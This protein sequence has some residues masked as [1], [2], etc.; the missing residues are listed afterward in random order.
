MR[1]FRPRIR[2][3]LEWSRFSGG[4]D[5]RWVARDPLTLEY[6]YFSGEEK[7]AAAALD[8]GRT[9]SEILHQPGRSFP[10]RT[11][12]WILGF[13][14][15]MDGSGLL[16]HGDAGRAGR[17]WRQRNARQKQGWM[18]TI[19]SPLSLRVPLFDPSG[20]MAGSGL[21]GR[22][23]FSRP[24]AL[25]WLVVAAVTGWL[26]LSRA[27]ASPLLFWQSFEAFR[28]ENLVWLVLVWIA[29]KSLHEFGHLLACRR[30][31][32]SCREVGLM[33]LVFVPCFYCDTSD[34]WKLG[35]RWRRAAIAAAGIYVELVLATLGGIGWLVFQPGLLQGISAHLLLLCTVGTLL[36]NGN[37]LMRYDGY[38]VFADLWGVPNLAEQSR[39]VLQAWRRYW[40]GGEKIDASRWD[41]RPLWLG[42][43][44]LAAL[45]Y[46]YFVVIMILVVVWQVFE[47]LGFSLAAILLGGLTA[48]GILWTWLRGLQGLLLEMTGGGEVKWIRGI[49]LVALLTAA[50]W[51]VAAVRFPETARSRAVCGWTH[52][53][54]VFANR[55]G[56]LVRI[57]SDGEWIEK[58]ETVAEIDDPGLHLQLLELDSELE[59]VR[60]RRDQ[61]QLLSVDDATTGN[62]LLGVD[63]QLRELGERR[64]ILDGEGRGLTVLAETAG[65]VLAGELAIGSPLAGPSGSSE[66]KQV[67]DRRYLGLAVERGTLLCWLA[68]PGSFTVR[69]CVPEDIQERLAVGDEVLCRWDSDPG[70]AYG[71]RIS[72]I[73]PETLVETPPALVGD[74]AFVSQRD[75]RGN[76]KPSRPSYEVTLEM[77]GMP[78]QPASDS[79]VTVHFRTGRTTLFE[80]A[81]RWI[82][83]SLRSSR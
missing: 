12:E 18:G 56:E 78:D 80:R 48:A 13:V 3:D 4:S 40:M 2:P 15:Q 50:V 74:A 5:D 22:L 17:L 16:T 1:S 83:Q 64:R 82:R 43:Y 10:G 68:D 57:R 34:S 20:L 30:W 69:A 37:P 45:F 73:A 49:V 35:S 11:G 51:T 65:R 54:P 62:R 25:F 70:H 8:G 14:R 41:A 77:D 71:G 23:V 58:G 28:G 36:L 75:P 42:L 24:L 9:L 39:E 31:D 59:L 33:F 53:V 27:L 32:A 66:G 67:L 47:Q 60:A 44:G 52:R 38:Y 63:E 7:M 6:F 55:N 76:W 81:E 29:V 79:L 19:L 26:V 46:R 72:G 21:L 61:L